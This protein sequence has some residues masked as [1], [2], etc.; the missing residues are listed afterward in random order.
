MPVLLRNATRPWA[1]PLAG[2]DGYIFDSDEQATCTSTEAGAQSNAG[3][4]DG[5]A[6]LPVA[7]LHANRTTNQLHPFRALTG[8][9][10]ARAISELQDAGVSGVLQRPI[11]TFMDAT[12][13]AALVR[14]PR[15]ASR[16]YAK[17]VRVD[18][19]AP[20]VLR[21]VHPPPLRVAGGRVT[22]PLADDGVHLWVGAPARGAPIVTDLHKDSRANLLAMV[23]GGRGRKRVLVLPPS[24][25]A[26]LR[27]AT[28]VDVMST[29]KSMP[30]AATAN[31]A[32][33]ADAGAD[34]AFDVHDE[35]MWPPTM[36]HTLLDRQHYAVSLAEARAMLR[37]TADHATDLPAA[38]EPAFTPSESICEFSVEASTHDAIFIPPGYV[39]AVETMAAD[40]AAVAADVLP[41]EDA[42]ASATRPRPAAD[43]SVAVSFFYN[44]PHDAVCAALGVGRQRLMGRDVECE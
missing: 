10:P 29:A 27:P 42:R 23:G 24:A 8:H 35:P 5:S 39:H 14:S 6:W 9:L 19:S 26:P 36:E 28:L 21:H 7:M 44:V 17:Q 4:G 33:A 16:C 11:V 43:V 20:H 1:V 12:T 30:T 41:Q 40:D 34:A 2:I 15:C 3:G 25:D 18:L 13:F 38:T 22:L 37:P 32:D 31:A